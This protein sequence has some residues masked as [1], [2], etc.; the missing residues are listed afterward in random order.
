MKKPS[1]T[2]F[3]Y[4]YRDASN[5]KAFGEILLTG[6]M[7]R[8]SIQKLTDCFEDYCLFVAEQVRI[9]VLYEQLYQYSDGPTDDDHVYHEFLLCRSATPQEIDTLSSWGS[10]QDFLAAFQNA[11]GKWDL[12]LS[13]HADPYWW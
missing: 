2:V 8:A 13:P 3:E 6:S 5:Y 10:T 11:K 4:L 9:P 12:M 7:S 1:Y